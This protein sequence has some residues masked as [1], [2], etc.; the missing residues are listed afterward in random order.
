MVSQKLSKTPSTNFPHKLS[1]LQVTSLTVPA[2]ESCSAA[3]S[4]L[5]PDWLLLPGAAPALA[6]STEV[7]RMSRF[8]SELSQKLQGGSFVFWGCLTDEKQEVNVTDQ[9]PPK[10]TREAKGK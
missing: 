9:K 6:D 10:K 1:L 8:I 7:W 2:A 4:V 3:P 5:R